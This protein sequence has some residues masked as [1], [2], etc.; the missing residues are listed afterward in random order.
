MAFYPCDVT[1][2][3]SR[4]EGILMSEIKITRVL[5][6]HCVDLRDSVQ[7]PACCPSCAKESIMKSQVL[8]A[9]K[10]RR[11]LVSVSS[12]SSER[13][14]DASHQSL[15]LIYGKSIPLVVGFPVD[16]RRLRRSIAVRRGG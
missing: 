15:C 16:R 2:Y 5:I 9:R 10:S 13:G 4:R 6:T 1:L 3:G 7:N 11:R 12:S 8:N 14:I